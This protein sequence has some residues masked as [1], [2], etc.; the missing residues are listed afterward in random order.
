MNI[1]Q[2]VHF[3]DFEYLSKR[4]MANFAVKLGNWK[5]DN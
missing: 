4:E 5:S 3:K 1:V 2:L